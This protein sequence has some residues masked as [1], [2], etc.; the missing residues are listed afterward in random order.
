MFLESGHI[1]GYELQD[2]KKE[3]KVTAEVARQGGSSQ[4]LCSPTSLLV[5]QSEQ[6][7]LGSAPRQ[8]QRVS[9]AN[10][11][12]WS[13]V[14]K[15]AAGLKGN[16]QCLVDMLTQNVI[17]Q[18]RNGLAEISLYSVLPISLYLTQMYTV[19]WKFFLLGSYEFMTF[20]CFRFTFFGVNSV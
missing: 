3:K 9:A 5:I 2:W 19:I 20:W 11:P 16:G 1:K 14:G 15:V 10:I 7:T 17:F 4:A 8:S 12:T 13:M 6:L 18:E